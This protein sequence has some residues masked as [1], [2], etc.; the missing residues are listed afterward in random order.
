V[1]SRGWDEQHSRRILVPLDGSSLAAEILGPVAELAASLGGAEIMLLAVVGRPEGVYP[2]AESQLVSDPIRERAQATHYLE[3]VASEV[4]AWAPGSVTCRIAYGD[5]A[6][7][8]AAVAAESD[9]DAIALAT[10]GR[11]GVVRLVLGSI[12]T[13]ALQLASVPVLVY[14]PDVVPD[15]AD[16]LPGTEAFRGQ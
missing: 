8:I 3:T 6:S 1:C 16:E 2:D 11:G 14:R 4:A 15:P 9:V 10:H 5:A 7:T 13:R 12:A